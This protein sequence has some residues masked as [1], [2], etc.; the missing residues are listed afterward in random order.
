VIALLLLLNAALAMP[1]GFP[2]QPPGQTGKR[3]LVQIDAPASVEARAGKEF[4]VPLKFY[5]QDGYHINSNK[6]TEEYL[7]GTH[8]EWDPSSAKHLDDVFPPAD[9]KEFGFSKGKKLSVFEGM[10]TMKARFTA[11]A[12]SGSVVLDGVFKY[13]ACDQRACYPPG[14]VPIHV[15]VKVADK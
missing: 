10:R 7:I 5:V 4:E 1:G 2:G 14:K 3:N 12:S 9:M 15:T 6:P 13:Q 11:P 8:I